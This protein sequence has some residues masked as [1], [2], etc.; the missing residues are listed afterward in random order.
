MKADLHMHSTYSD[1]LLTPEGLFKK[2]KENKIDVISITDHDTIKQ[3]DKNFKLA[4]KYNVKYI[5]GIELSCVYKEKSVH[6]LG[7]FTDDSY[8]SKALIDYFTH[9]KKKR[10]VRARNFLQNLKTYFDFDIEYDR[11]KYFSNHIIARPHIAKAIVEK[12][13]KYSFDEVF[14]RFISD[15]SKAYIPSCNLKIE[16]GLKLL[17]DHNCL[18]VLAH[19]TLL[20]KA[21]QTHVLSHDYDGLEAKY[22]R[23][24]ELDEKRFR[25]LAQ[26]RN[27]IITG[28][29]DYHGIKNDSN[30]GD[31]G[32][33]YLD[34]TDL[35]KFLD[36][37]K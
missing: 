17:R 6:I 4:K 19:P 20:E 14:D 16:E 5:P 1:G 28:G 3:P 26:T 23:N 12:Y 11:V 7:Y 18:V 35:D 29:S 15:S 30:H 22:Y 27:M 32:E 31:L 25:D 33:I 13:P 9:I 21:H 10:E 34:K 24:K 2:A 8:K 36:E 37:L